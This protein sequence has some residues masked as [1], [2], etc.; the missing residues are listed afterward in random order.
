MSLMHYISA[1]KEL[2]LG[3]IGKKEPKQIGMS[4][5]KLKK[6]KAC[7]P[8]ETLI[9][10]GILVPEKVKVY[11][12][13]DDLGIIKIGNIYDG[14]EVVKKHLKNKFVYKLYGSF[15]LSERLKNHSIESYN[16][17]KK[18]LEELFKYIKENISDE[19]E[20]EIY[21][22]WANEEGE[23]RNMELDKVID[24][25]SFII[26]ESFDFIEKEY[27]VIKG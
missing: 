21:T 23:E 26:P 2:P 6:T 3:V 11:D 24:L 25:K 17:H 16:R 13:L 8:I 19:E 14:N 15:H 5:E 12:S 9:E 4:L 1:N 10:K 18:C 20:F 7:M 22:C 27:I